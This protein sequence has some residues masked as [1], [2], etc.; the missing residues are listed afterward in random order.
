[1]ETLNPLIQERWEFGALATGSHGFYERLGWERWRGPSYVITE[2]GTERSAEE[3]DG[4]MVLRFGPS[5]DVELTSSITCYDRP[6]D[7][8]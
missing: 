1:M 8:W 5:A 6:G 7:A 2:H 4:L 3:D